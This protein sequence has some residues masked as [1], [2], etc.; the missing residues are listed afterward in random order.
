MRFH[1]LAAA[2]AAIT[3]ADEV[4][5]NAEPA[6]V[7]TGAGEATLGDYYYDNINCNSYSDDYYS[8]IYGGKVSYNNYYDL[9]NGEYCGYSDSWC[10]SNY[11]TSTVCAY[12]SYYIY[13]PSY[14]YYADVNDLIWLWWTLAALSLV[15]TII[16]IVCVVCCIKKKRRQQA[17]IAQAMHGQH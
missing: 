7:D 17:E 5:Y 15:I 9:C 10:K 8:S 3:F 14:Y 1:I 11:C 6:L 13:T 4:I 12:T 16:V 2:I